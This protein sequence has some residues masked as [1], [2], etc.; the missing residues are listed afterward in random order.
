MP[1]LLCRPL[2]ICWCV[3]V[4]SFAFEDR[5][6][7]SDVWSGLTLEFVHPANSAVQDTISPNVRLTRGAIQGLYNA[8][9]ESGYL[10]NYSPE[11]TLWATEINN[12]EV[13]VEDISATNAEQLNF[14]VWQIAYGGQLNLASSIVGS[15]AVLYLELDDV[16]LDIQ[17][18]N[19][20]QGN[21]SGGAFSYLRAEPPSSG[22]TG[23]YNSDG[24]VDAADYTIWRNTLGSMDDL[25]AN[26]D[27]TG[28]S[29][30]VIDQADFAFWKSHFGDIVPGPGGTGAMGAVV[31]EPAL[32]VSLS[33]V[34]ALV[35]AAARIRR[36]SSIC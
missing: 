15:A 1:S 8:E 21:G 28:L 5:A 32:V 16:F 14:D 30:N 23:D 27:N 11:F 36:S 35:L 33:G 7:A 29:A 9:S 13:D 10:D 3:A 26:G 20:S 31:P 17:F 4:A 6:L 25:R 2:V 22:P 12:P 18:T 34:A 24:F 19:W